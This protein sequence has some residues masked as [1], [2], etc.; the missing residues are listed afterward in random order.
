MLLERLE[1]PFLG[2]RVYDFVQE[3]TEVI[4]I[5]LGQVILSYNRQFVNFINQLEALSS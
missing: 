3:P 1:L 2:M 4:T 5:P